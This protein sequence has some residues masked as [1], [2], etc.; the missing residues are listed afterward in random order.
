[1]SFILQINNAT[2]LRKILAPRLQPQKNNDGYLG[3]ID[4][5]L[6]FFDPPEIEAE[7]RYNNLIGI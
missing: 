4:S 3:V 6:D 7:K 5:F 1:M 2:S